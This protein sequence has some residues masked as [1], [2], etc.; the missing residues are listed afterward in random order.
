ME[1]LKQ[2]T[3]AADRLRPTRVSIKR[4]EVE[5]LLLRLDE[6]AENVNSKKESNDRWVPLLAEL[7]VDTQHASSLQQ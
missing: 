1:R 4:G 5:A 7:G 6:A 2:Y 3:A